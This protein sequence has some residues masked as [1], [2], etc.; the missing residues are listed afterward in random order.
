[1]ISGPICT[2]EEMISLELCFI[3]DC[4]W[5]YSEDISHSDFRAAKEQLWAI[6]EGMAWPL[7]KTSGSV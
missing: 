1:M 4:P 7:T 2:E 5:V 6:R 3:V